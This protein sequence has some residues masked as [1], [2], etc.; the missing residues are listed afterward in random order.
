MKRK[1]EFLYPCIVLDE[2][3]DAEEK[4]FDLDMEIIEPPLART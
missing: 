1:D 4:E 2:A 3:M